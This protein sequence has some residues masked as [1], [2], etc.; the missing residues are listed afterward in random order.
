MTENLPRCAVLARQLGERPIGTASKIQSVLL[1]EHAGPWAVDVRERVLTECFGPGG[2]ELLDELH[3]RLGLRALVVRRPGRGAAP[4]RPSVFF[5]GCRPGNRWLERL[6]VRDYRELADLDLAAV[7]QGP[8][9]IGE[10]VEHP[11]FLVCVHGRKD[12][13]CAIKG[14]PVANALAEAYPDQTWQCTHFGGDRWAGNLLIAPHGFMYGQLDAGSAPPIAAAARHGRVALSNLR[15]RTGISPFAQVAEIAVR[16]RT[17][18]DGLDEVLA[19]EVVGDREDAAVTVTAVATG[20]T[21]LYRVQVRR[22]SLGVHGHSLC[23]GEAHPHR[24]D[25]LGVEISVPA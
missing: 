10:P 3:I 18:L 12:A 4:D 17:G 23:S 22:R 6:T 13:C 21:E 15:G 19:G 7:A 24:F 14:R 8:G 2:P 5:G 11:F 25:V 1:I 16:E 20:G 9:G